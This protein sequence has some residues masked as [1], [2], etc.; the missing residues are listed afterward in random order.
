[1]KKTNN[2][3][4]DF[5][6]RCRSLQWAN[7]APAHPTMAPPN[8]LLQRGGVARAIGRSPYCRGGVFGSETRSGARWGGS[9]VSTS[10]LA[11]MHEFCSLSILSHGFPFLLLYVPITRNAQMAHGLSY[12]CSMQGSSQRSPGVQRFHPARRPITR[13]LTCNGS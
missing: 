3:F 13:A 1:M 9:A 11:G 8:P 2:R 6:E 4:R 7:Q 10:V 5:P 12:Q